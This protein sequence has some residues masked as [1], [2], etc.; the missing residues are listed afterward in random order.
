M[1]VHQRVRECTTQAVMYRRSGDENQLKDVRKRDSARSCLLAAAADGGD[2]ECC[3]KVVVVVVVVLP[4]G[5][6]QSS[7]TL[8]S[9][10][11]THCS[12]CGC[13]CCFPDT[14]SEADIGAIRRS[15][16]TA[17]VDHQ[18][19]RRQ[20]CTTHLLPRLPAPRVLLQKKERILE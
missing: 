4:Q 3:R 7:R 20:Q 12:C 8:R 15:R 18:S 1:M 5:D 11:I 19:C 16:L 6:L 17:Q 10:R 2:G 13:C 9:Q 14:T